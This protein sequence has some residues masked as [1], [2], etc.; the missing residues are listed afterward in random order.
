MYNQ[1]KKLKHPSNQPA[2]QNHNVLNSPTPT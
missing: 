1:D 2:V